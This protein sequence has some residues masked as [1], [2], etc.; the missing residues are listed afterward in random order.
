MDY[1]HDGFFADADVGGISSGTNT[2]LPIIAKPPS[3]IGVAIPNSTPPANAATQQLPPN[4]F[5][6]NG[7]L[8]Y[9]LN[10]EYVVFNDQLPYNSSQGIYQGRPILAKPTSMKTSSAVPFDTTVNHT[11][12]TSAQASTSGPSG[13]VLVLYVVIILIV[14]GVVGFGIYRV[15]FKKEEP[16]VTPANMSMPNMTPTA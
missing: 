15:I 6:L 4:S 7:D 16:V 8:V 9:V 13:G 11:I 2:S 5:T 3:R 12:E 14:F 10:G 1:S